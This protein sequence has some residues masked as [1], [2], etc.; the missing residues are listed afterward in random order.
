MKML[1]QKGLLLNRAKTKNV[2]DDKNDDT[3]RLIVLNIP[4]LEGTT[5]DSTKIFKVED[6]PDLSEDIKTLIADINITNNPNPTMIPIGS[7]MI[8][9]RRAISNAGTAACMFVF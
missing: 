3:K 4:L 7:S 8:V 6:V 2:H 5:F 1:K 9:I